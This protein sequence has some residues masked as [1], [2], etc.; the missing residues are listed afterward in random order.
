MLVFP[1]TVLQAV[2]SAPGLEVKTS[3]RHVIV[4]P[5][6]R[7][8]DLVVTTTQYV[9]V[10][11]LEPEAKPADTVVIEDARLAGEP[12]R[13]AGGRSTGHQEAVI[14]L[15]RGAMTGRWP[16]GAAPRPLAREAVPTWV[17]LEPESILGATVRRAGG[18]Y[19]LRRYVLVNRNG[20]PRSYREQEFYTGEEFGIAI[21]RQVVEPGERLV[22][23]VVVPGREAAPDADPW[24]ALDPDGTAKGAGDESRNHAAGRAGVPGA[25]GRPAGP[26]GPGDAPL[27]ALGRRRVRTGRPCHPLGLA[28]SRRARRAGRQ[29]GAGQAALALAQQDRA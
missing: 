22:L 4:S 10:L 5:P 29:A 9:Y 3:D 6:D 19:E 12:A 26:V 16:A 14:E 8:V 11:M 21:S 24:A 27:G 1:A 28:V 13:A 20:A 2:T 17:D 7:P 23:G 15:L 25:G 18:L